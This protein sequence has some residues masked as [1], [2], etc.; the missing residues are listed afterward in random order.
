MSGTAPRPG[1]P[2]VTPLTDKAS[3]ILAPVWLRFF[4]ELWTR[5]GGSIAK[6]GMSP[7]VVASGTSFGTAAELLSTTNIITT[8]AAGAG[9]RLPTPT[10]G[11]LCNIR[12]RSANPV[13]VY[14]GP[15]LTI[16][17]QAAGASV[18]LAVGADAVFIASSGVAWTM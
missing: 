2:G 12:N 16:E 13:L 5:T 9:V 7:A 8:C 18:S 11:M 3:G 1:F 15:A 6:G 4:L 14:P 10:A 17:A